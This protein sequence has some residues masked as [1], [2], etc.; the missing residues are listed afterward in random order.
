M[1]KPL[2]NRIALV[3]GASRGIGRAAALALAQAG[4]HVIAVA[5]T[6]GA[7]EELDDAIQA[8]G[9]T[10]TLVPLDIRDFPALDRL[11]HS[12]FERWGR[13]DA[14][15]G[16]AGSL[17]V[18]TPLSH[19]EPKTFQEVIEVNVTANW[20]LIR[21]FD[22]LLRRSDAGRV[23]FVSSAAARFHP[24]YWGAYNVS[25]AALESLAFTYAAE[26][27]ETPVRVNLLDPGAVRTRMRAVAF[28][29]E[30]PMTLP[31]PEALAPLIVALLSPSCT[32]NGERVEFRAEVS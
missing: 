1:T 32:K 30:D 18:L 9:G 20:R 13:L 14:V 11:G 6:S 23:L 7:L 17:G 28:P 2:A 22:L 4:A 3:T 19:L 24:A 21:S 29:G 16:N 27:K 10:A 31:P 12:I 26:C 15:L 25:K 5:R 8:A